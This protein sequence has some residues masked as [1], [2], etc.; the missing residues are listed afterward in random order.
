MPSAAAL[1]PRL[2][3]TQ[4]SLGLAGAW[5]VALVALGGS[6]DKVETDRAHSQALHVAV[7]AIDHYSAQAQAATQAHGTVLAAFARAAKASNLPD[8]KAAV[9]TQV[10]PAMDE[11]LRTLA[12]VRADTPELQA[13]HARLLAAYAKARQEV[14]AFEAGLTEAAGLR[15]FEPVRTRLHRAVDAYRSELSA[16]CVA[17][18]HAL[19][20]IPLASAVSSVEAP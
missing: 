1:P 17:N 4:R 19:T 9:R 7:A 16:Y 14:D 12:A 15:A 10:L 20:P 6:C 2:P 11:F 5:L 8:Y 3:H 18:Q 13:I